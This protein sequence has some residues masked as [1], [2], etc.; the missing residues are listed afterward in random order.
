MKFETKRLILRPAKI[1]DWKDILEGAGDI[2]VA[3]MT[4]GISHPYEKKDAVNWIKQN[5]K[6]WKKKQK[7]GYSWVIE[8]KSEKKVIG[9]TGIFNIDRF[10]DYAETGSWINKKYWKKGYIVEA[11]IP[12][13][14]FVFNKLKLRKLVTVTFR[15]N[16]ASN[17][18]SK[19]L[20]Y[21]L[22]GKL[23]RHEKCQA[24]GKIHNEN[25]YGLLKED[26]EKIRQKIIKKMKR[27]LK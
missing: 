9:T 17:L 15:N 11:K 23:R 2:R 5:I 19:K 18:M 3:K 20:G 25:M 16:K 12:I 27:R 8:L 6:K 10:G 13:I 26:W 7:K 21:K 1:G 4:A 22:E 14:D 24:T